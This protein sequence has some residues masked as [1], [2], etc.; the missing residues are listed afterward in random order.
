MVARSSPLARFPDCRCLW[1]S[2]YRA[3]R[4]RFFSLPSVFFGLL[5]SFPSSPLYNGLFLLV[6]L[7]DRLHTPGG[8]VG[9]GSVCSSNS[10]IRLLFKGVLA[11]WLFCCKTS[12][13]SSIVCETHSLPGNWSI[14]G[15]LAGFVL[16]DSEDDGNAS[17]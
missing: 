11:P 9:V 5:V 2:S 10:Y 1:Q 14:V 3:D 12:R 15:W 16:V 7:L 8:S 4:P 17:N 13:R 6:M